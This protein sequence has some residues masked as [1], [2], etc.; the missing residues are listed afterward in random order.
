MKLGK[1]LISFYKFEKN[2]LKKH[3]N[4]F[5]Q[6]TFSQQQNM[7]SSFFLK[8]LIALMLVLLSTKLNRTTTELAHGIKAFW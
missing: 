6:N 8:D 7:V 4:N 2:N 3:S 5:Q 1:N